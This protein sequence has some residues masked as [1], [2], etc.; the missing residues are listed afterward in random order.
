MTDLQRLFSKRYGVLKGIVTRWTNQGYDIESTY[1]PPKR[2]TEGSIRR[3]EKE[4]KE[5]QRQKS[6]AEAHK[7]VEAYKELRSKEK[8]EV[9]SLKEKIDKYL[10]GVTIGRVGRENRLGHAG[11]GDGRPYMETNV[12]WMKTIIDEEVE[13]ATSTKKKE[14]LAS[15]LKEAKDELD[16][17]IE[18]IVLAVYRDGTAVWSGGSEQFKI[19]KDSFKTLIQKGGI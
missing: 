10:D 12:T 7:E 13:K 4:I 17:V 8:S 5:V 9:K 19:V 1:E 16:V 15:R 11:R 6:V 18:E 2:I 3:I 14:A